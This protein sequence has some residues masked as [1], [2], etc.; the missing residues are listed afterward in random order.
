MSEKL[1]YIWLAAM[2][3]TGTFVVVY[4]KVNRQSESHPHKTSTSICTYHHDGHMFVRYTGGGIL[5]H[6]DCHCLK[7]IEK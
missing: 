7:P 2:I 3:L 1:F 5:H 6:P 4:V